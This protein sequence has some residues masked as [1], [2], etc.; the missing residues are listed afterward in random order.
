[1][2]LK[3]WSF[4]ST[5]RW[6]LKKQR[7]RHMTALS[8][9]SSLILVK[10]PV[11]RHIET[12]QLFACLTIQEETAYNRK[13]IARY[14][15]LLDFVDHT[16]ISYPRISIHRIFRLISPQLPELR[17]Y[18]ETVNV[19]A[20]FHCC[21]ARLKCLLRESRTTQKIKTADD[22]LFGKVGASAVRLYGSSSKKMIF[23]CRSS[24]F[25]KYFSSCIIY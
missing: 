18:W 2:S 23:L 25:P 14:N 7:K 4:L 9:A 6:S 17:H 12:W 5:I 21:E 22:R 1:M 16:R 3:G 13:Q 24:I 8:A 15:S 20:P 10:R 11:R 19:L